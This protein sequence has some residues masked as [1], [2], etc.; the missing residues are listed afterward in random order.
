VLKNRWVLVGLAL[1]L[2][3][4]FFIDYVA[5]LLYPSFELGSVR[6]PDALGGAHTYNFYKDTSFVG[7]YTYS[8]AKTSGAAQDV[9]YAMS[10]VTSI[11][12]EGKPLTLEGLYR[13]NS[14]FSPVGYGLNATEASGI[15]YYVCDFKPGAVTA[16][17]SFQ[18]ETIDVETEVEEGTLLIE[19]SMP[20]YWEILFQ[21]TSLDRGKRYT[22]DAFIPQAARVFHV[23]LV[24]EK[25]LEQVR[26]EEGTL[27]CTVIKASDLGLAFYV[28]QGEIVQYRNEEQGVLM[29]K[30]S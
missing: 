1:I 11:T 8:V 3:G 29:S 22:F 12:F 26:V 23:T 7:T 21:S 13:F 25:D 5:E 2:A 19:N 4:V 16:S 15:T 10:S 27:E 14:G 9:V 24:V 30:T 20:G 28:N 18:G 6:V 17:V